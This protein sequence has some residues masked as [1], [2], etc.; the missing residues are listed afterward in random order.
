[1]ASSESKREE[2]AV[3]ELP[4]AHARVQRGLF[5]VCE[6]LDGDR[7]DKYTSESK[8]LDIAREWAD[9]MIEHYGEV[10][11]V[12]DDGQSQKSTRLGH[13]ALSAHRPLWVVSD[14]GVTIHYYMAPVVDNNA[15]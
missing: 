10:L 4:D 1:M 9:G 12:S 15:A 3:I 7:F 8:R 11:G 14:E 5:A 2:W 6:R 13:L